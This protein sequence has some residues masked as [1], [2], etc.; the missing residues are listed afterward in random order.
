MSADLLEE[1]LPVAR[2]G[3]LKLAGAM[4]IED[5]A[6]AYVV[7]EVLEALPTIPVSADLTAG[8][9]ETLASMATVLAGEL[10][11]EEPLR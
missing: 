8:A 7:G 4:A 10:R 11:G 6:S 3:L 9:L 1:R 2:L 5:R